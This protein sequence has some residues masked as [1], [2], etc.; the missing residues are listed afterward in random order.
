MGD[1]YAILG[2]AKTAT[3]DE[4]RRAYRRLA[5]KHHP[6]LNPGDAAA[7]ARF[8]DISAAHDLL[9]DT[10]KRRRFDAGEI[11]AA[12]QEQAPR[13]FYR[14]FAGG[15]GGAKYRRRAAPEEFG[16]LGGM[17]SGLFGDGGGFGPSGGT[18]TYAL[19]VRFLDAAR[20]AKRR[21]TMPDGRMLD[22]EIPEG[23]EDRQMLRLKGQGL[24]GRDGQPGDA[25]VELHIEPH[26]F[27]ERRDCNVHL[28]LPV[29]PAEAVLGGKLR[30]PTVGGP[31]M[32]AVPPG[33]NAGTTLRL[34]GRGLLDRRS[35]VRGD[36]YIKL[37]I[38]LPPQADDAL[39]RFLETWEAGR[40]HDPRRA[41]E[42][43]E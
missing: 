38:V 18:V 20:G 25:Y 5:K 24:P 19:P 1:P 43:F 30:V 34:K 12:G 8:K 31:V 17:F 15:P 40:A 39:K 7:E 27:F 2:V 10:E 4:I 28:E 6:D 9:S 32:L 13:G 3:A 37:R 33:S 22:I 16:D 11:D 26:A 23:V 41:M 14:D 36:Q 21:V 42:P 29:T 35:G